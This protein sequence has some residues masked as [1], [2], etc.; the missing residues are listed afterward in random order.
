MQS[1]IL[2]YNYLSAVNRLAATSE[3][4]SNSDFAD[5]L[6]AEYQYIAE[7]HFKTIEA[8]SSFFRY[9][10]II[11]G[12]PFT[13]YAVIIGL[14]Q[15]IGEI[16]YVLTALTASISL[17]IAIV[18]L[19]VTLYITNLRFD[20]ILY[21]RTV[22]GIRKHFYDKS[23]LD[24]NYKTRMRPLPQT[25]TI[26]GYFENYFL[27]VIVSFAIFDAVYLLIG[28]S[29]FLAPLP[30]FSEITSFS[31]IGKLVTAIPL[32]IW[33]TAIVFLF[34]HIVI[35]SI[36]ARWRE[37]TY[38][39][40]NSV[41]IDIDGVLNL[42][43]HQFCSVLN[44]CRGKVLSP[45]AISKIPVHED[46]SLQISEE[47][48]RA[49]FNTPSYWTEMPVAPEAAQNIRKIRNG[50]KLKIFIFT[51]RHSPKRPSPKEQIEE[52]TISQWKI[53][54]VE[55][56]EE[57]ASI[58]PQSVKKVMSKVFLARLQFRNN[59]RFGIKP[60]DYLTERW[61]EKNEIEYDKLIIEKGSDDASDPRGQFRNRFY[62]SRKKKIKFFVE[63]DPEKALK[64]SFI[65]DF[66]FLMEQSYNALEELP[67]NVI[68]VRNWNEVFQQIRKYS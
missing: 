57:L 53:A 11:M 4:S 12:L 5:Y 29:I 40:S 36:A 37:L 23:D 20:A 63:D 22:N 26:P 44:V 45:A 41:G 7:A 27:P 25:P 42:H 66:V 50:L 32:W 49:V 8:I 19:F 38:L 48:E 68:R 6:L 17:I 55:S 59:A 1:T 2:S 51:Y 54:S 52:K 31:G 67:S 18:G 58:M 61:L 16:I 10:L 28:A 34:I 43:R 46:S 65:C 60:I 39:K 33:I 3:Q 56:Y 24:L 30:N 47:D 9:Y 62:I 14:S 13:L 64:L 35:Y 21:A 15:Q